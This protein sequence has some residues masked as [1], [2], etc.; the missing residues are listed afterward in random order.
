MTEDQ[1]KQ[2]QQIR[3]ELKTA[4][5]NNDIETLK[6]KMAQLEQAAAMAQ[7]YQQQSQQGGPNPEPQQN[8]N[9]DDVVDVDFTEKN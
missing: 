7:Q 2:T 6:Q 3:D 1:K 5:D 9:N 4:L 8:N